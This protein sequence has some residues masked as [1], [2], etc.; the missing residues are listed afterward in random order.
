MTTK[1]IFILKH[2]VAHQHMAERLRCNRHTTVTY[3][4]IHIG[5]SEELLKM[6]DQVKSANDELCRLKDLSI[7]ED[8]ER[9]VEY[10]K[11]EAPFKS[12]GQMLGRVQ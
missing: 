1:T 8:E 10:V 7:L 2:S 5:S 6:L 11:R 12:V 3:T 9:F 4:V